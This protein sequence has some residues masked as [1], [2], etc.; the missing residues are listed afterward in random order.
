M[1]ADYERELKG[2]LAGDADSVR[3]VTVSATPEE[4]RDYRRILEHPFLVV[5]GAGSLGV[6]LVALRHDFSFPLEVKSS[7]KPTIAFSRNERMKEQ[8][9]RMQAD[10]GRA[11]VIP[12]YAFRLKAHRGDPW[13]L[14][15][16]EPANAF[17]GRMRI[18]Q[19]KVPRLGVS[20]AGNYILHFEKGLKLSGFIAFLEFLRAPMEPTAVAEPH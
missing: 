10:C 11:G 4:G 9:D 17:R 1:G 18:L 8:A 20:A 12:M 15:A 2:I 5:R 6:D 14:F 16:M 13:R 3:Q 7:A 19:E